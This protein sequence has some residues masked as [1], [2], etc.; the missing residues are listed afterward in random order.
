MLRRRCPSIGCFQL[1][2]SLIQKRGGCPMLRQLAL[3]SFILLTP[4]LVCAQT[5]KFKIEE[6]TIEDIQGAIQ[7]G[8]LT[9]TQVVQLYLNRIKVYNGACVRMPDGVLGAGPITPIKHAHQINALI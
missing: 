6:A 4:S 8:E 3:A 7:R 1:L 5:T 9:S 2:S